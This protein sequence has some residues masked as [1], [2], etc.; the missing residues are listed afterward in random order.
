MRNE[1]VHRFQRIEFPK[2]K[3]L[4]TILLIYLYIFYSLH[5]PRNKFCIFYFNLEVRSTL[6]L[7]LLNMCVCYTYIIFSHQFCI[8][9]P[10][11]LE[12][13]TPTHQNE[14][15]NIWEME[16]VFSPFSIKK[17]EIKTKIYRICIF[18]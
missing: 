7:F 6:A 10:S 17:I 11:P 18:N 2:K 1:I 15:W 14:R 4:N 13:T 5:F 12:Y 3:N 9:P 8:F 16:I